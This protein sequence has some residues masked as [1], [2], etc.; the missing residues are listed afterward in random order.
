[1]TTVMLFYAGMAVIIGI[2]FYVGYH[3]DRKNAHRR[4]ETPEEHCDPLDPSHL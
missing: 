3:V 1:M 4:E 2:I